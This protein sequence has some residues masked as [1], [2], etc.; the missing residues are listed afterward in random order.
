VET[1]GFLEAIASVNSTWSI[2][3]FAIAAILAVLK[4]AAG[5]GPQAK[6]LLAS[7][8]VWGVV[9]VV[10]VL[11]VLPIL[12]D[13]YLKH[14]QQVTLTIYR[15]RVTVLDPQ[16]VPVS[17]ATLR[18]TASNETTTTSQG[19]GEVAIPKGSMPG[20]GKV[21]IYADLDPAFLHGHT[22]LQLA[23]D[24][25]PSVKIELKSNPNAVV[26]GLVE[27]ESGAA[28]P[29]AAVSVLGGEAGVTSANGTFTLK[30][31]APVGQQV[32]LHAE[33]AGYNP[34]DQDRPAGPEPVTIVLVQKH[35]RKRAK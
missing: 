33:K 29:D 4:L 31:N 6:G 30:T 25:N 22:D 5:R 13:T 23:D 14:A 21:T 16:G 11:G 20:D 18:S 32:R 24:P 28:V 27:D 1:K 9:I 34:V 3:A 2:A 15:V 19:I 17:G 10:C 7:S 8:I 26:T 12:A 35:A